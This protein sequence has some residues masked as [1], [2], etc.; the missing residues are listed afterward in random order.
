MFSNW[1]TTLAGVGAILLAA[2]HLLT[3]VSTGG[4]TGNELFADGAAI[5]TGIG[6]LFG[7]DWN[8]TGGNKSA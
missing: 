4:F 1:K 6:L 5:V 2:G 3:S 8:I 7:K